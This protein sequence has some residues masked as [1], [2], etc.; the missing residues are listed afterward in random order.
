MLAH[1]YR[2]HGAVWVF[3]SIAGPDAQIT[4]PSGGITVS[5]AALYERVV[6]EEA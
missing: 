1:I 4:L 2:R 5:L 3:E 6:P